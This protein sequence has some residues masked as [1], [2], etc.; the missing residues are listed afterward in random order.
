[1]EL[2]TTPSIGGIQH[3]TRIAKFVLLE[4]LDYR[5]DEV[6]LTVLYSPVQNCG[7][8]AVADPDFIWVCIDATCASRAFA[9]F[10]HGRHTTP[11][12]QIH[13]SE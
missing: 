11:L 7:A 6:E 9:K 5:L 1:M 12:S 2:R 13:F 10:T 8:K 4:P 3:F